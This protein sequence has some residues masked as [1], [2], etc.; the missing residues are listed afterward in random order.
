M[1]QSVISYLKNKHISVIEENIPEKLT[2]WRQWYEGKVD[3]FHDYKIYTGKKHLNKERKTLNMAAKVCQRWAD[4]ALNEKVE[5]SVTDEYTQEKLKQLLKQVN[6][7]VRGNNLLESAFALGGGFFIQYWDGKKTSQKYITQEY[8]YP[9]SFDSGRLRE[10]AFSSNRTIAGKEYTYLETHLLDENGEYVIDNS[11]LETHGNELIEVGESFYKQYNI[12]PKIET[13]R[14]DPC[15]QMIR[16][17]VANKKKFDSPFGTSVFAG[18]TD[19]FKVCDA[20]FDSYYKEFILG[21]KRIFASED[22]AN[23]NYVSKEGQGGEMVPV[24]DPNDE[25]FYS[26]RDAEN[27]NPPIQESN[28]ALRVAEHDQALQTQLNIISQLCGFGANGFKWE[29]NGLATATQIISENSD[30]FRTLK[31]HEAIL[32]DAILD[33]A[34]GLLYFEREFGGDKRINLDS[35]I[36]VDFDDSIIEDTAEIR[37]QAMLDYNAGLISKAEYFRQVYKLSREQAEQFVLDMAAEQNAELSL[38]RIQEEP[39]GA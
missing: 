39:E 9:I 31:K 33:M 21:K 24:F 13:H 17:N 18:A 34:K 5:F 1:D 19:A 36:T 22:I 8:M 3:G 23:Y 25:V 30:M 38:M 7:Y 14:S 28:M 16:P 27:K 37:R 15:F 29:S 35:D 10:A 26:L 6:F 20:V 12:E 32:R 2:V 4:L 11:L